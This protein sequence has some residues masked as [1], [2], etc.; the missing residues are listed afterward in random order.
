MVKE[1][2]SVARDPSRVGGSFLI[3]IL[4]VEGAEE[5][6]LEQFDRTKIKI[7]VKTSFE[8][9]FGVQMGI[10]KRNN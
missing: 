4:K 7:K 8:K 6:L 10:K 2:L 1:T 3:V 5:G 9:I